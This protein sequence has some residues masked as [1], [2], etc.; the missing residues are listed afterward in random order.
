M[1]LNHSHGGHRARLRKRFSRDS[2]NFEDHELLELVLF[3]A[4]PQKDTNALAH[5]LLQRFGS[6]NGVLNATPDQLKTVPGMGETSSQM[7]PAM[8]ELLR[9]YLRNLTDRKLLSGYDAT[10]I[11]SHYLSTFFGMQ[12]ECVLAIALN[13]DYSVKGDRMIG[14]GSFCSTQIN[15]PQLSRFISDMAPC[16]IVIAHNH[17]SGIALPSEADYVTT[18]RLR[19]FV[20]ECGST[21]VD[22]LIFDGQGDFVS[23]G[24]SGKIEEGNRYY[25]KVSSWEDKDGEIALVFDKIPLTAQFVTKDQIPKE[26]P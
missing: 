11:G 26:T 25:Y 20:F 2:R 7:F 14:Q 12:D 15:T 24:A 1:P 16:H 8:L 19:D 18:E 10:R 21:L 17:P 13:R 22:H 4:I 3:Y 23:M 5:D 6:L 9:R